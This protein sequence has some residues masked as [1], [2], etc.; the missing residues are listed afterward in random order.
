VDQNNCTC[1]YQEEDIHV[2]AGSLKLF[3][4]ELKEPLIPPE[5]FAKA[6][7]ACQLSSKD[8]ESKRK[9]IISLLPK[10]NKSTLQAL[11]SHLLRVAALHEFNRMQIPNLAIVFGPTLMYAAESQNMA[12]DLMQQNLVIEA[13]LNEYDSIFQ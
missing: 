1:L 13:L 2:L 9:D 7:L 10:P 6:L 11:L 5:L 8:N 12:T 3:F 4:R